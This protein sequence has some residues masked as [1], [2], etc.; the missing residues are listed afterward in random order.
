MTCA[1]RCPRGFSS[2]RP[3]RRPV[4]ARPFAGPQPPAMFDAV[5]PQIE[6]GSARPGVRRTAVRVAFRGLPGVRTQG[7]RHRCPHP[8]TVFRT[9]ATFGA[10]VRS[11]GARCRVCAATPRPWPLS[12]ASAPRSVSCS[13][14]PAWARPCRTPRP[15]RPTSG[16]RA[17]LRNPWRARSRS[18]AS[19]QRGYHGGAT[20]EWGDE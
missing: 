8:G 20:T 3:G 4:S 16:R 2:V 19:P 13:T 14:S 15:R 7:E 17:R 9:S 6:R 1:A 5:A 10:A 18:R 12:R 11:S